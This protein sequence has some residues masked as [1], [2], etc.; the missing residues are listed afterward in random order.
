MILRLSRWEMTIRPFL[1]WKML[2]TSPAVPKQEKKGNALHCN[3]RQLHAIHNNKNSHLLLIWM[4][5]F[6]PRY[7][8]TKNASILIKYDQKIMIS[9][10]ITYN[11]LDKICNTLH[12]WKVE[13]IYVPKQWIINGLADFIEKS[14]GWPPRRMSGHCLPS[15]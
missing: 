9:I 10:I 7:A 14:E 2:S 13:C 8:T 3:I 15:K 11:L 12:S 1:Y 6:C 5:T 4:R